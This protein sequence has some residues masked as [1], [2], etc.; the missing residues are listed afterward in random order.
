[1]TK[2]QAAPQ[3]YTVTVDGQGVQVKRTVS[4]AIAQEIIALTMGRSASAPAVAVGVDTSTSAVDVSQTAKVFLAGK[5]PTSDIERITC[6]AFYLTHNRGMTS[7]K[8]NDLTKLNTD[9]AQKRFSNPTV[10]ARNAVQQEY[11][12]L[13]GGGRKQISAR[14][15]AVVRA[16]P[17]RAE[18]KKALDAN[19]PSRRRKKKVASSKKKSP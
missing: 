15:E 5:R 7:F 10:A 9:A 1:M 14:G 11:L 3:P 16:L 6:L 13:A 2:P 8:T 4:E 17:D 19:P 18:V 12:A